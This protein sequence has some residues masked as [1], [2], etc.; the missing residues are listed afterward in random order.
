M[1][2]ELPVGE[3]LQDHCMAQLNFLTD[4]ESL[5][6]AMTPENIALFET[7]GRGPLTSNIPEAGAFFRTRPGSTR[8]TSSS[9]SRPRCST[10]RG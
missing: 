6:T 9:T 1:R 4:E 10:T 7:E 5:L 3:N 8:P 2:E